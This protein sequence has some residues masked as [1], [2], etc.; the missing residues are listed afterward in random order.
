MAD[1]KTAVPD[2]AALEDMH[3]ST[4]ADIAAEHGV[5]VQDKSKVDL[6]NEL[7]GDEKE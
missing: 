2:R 4:V 6:I 7:V 1:K 5:D 3:L